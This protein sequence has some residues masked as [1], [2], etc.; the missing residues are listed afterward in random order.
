MPVP[1][2]LGLVAGGLVLISLWV[3]ADGQPLAAYATKARPA[4]PDGAAAVAGRACPAA[5][6]SPG[7]VLHLDHLLLGQ[8]LR[9][10]GV[11]VGSLCLR[12]GLAHWHRQTPLTSAAGVLLCALGSLHGH[13]RAHAGARA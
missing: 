3:S 4:A 1:W 7:W 6:A 2:R 11:A 5:M 8:P 13:R 10:Q 12:I 9:Y